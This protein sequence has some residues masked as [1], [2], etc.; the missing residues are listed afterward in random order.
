MT[1]QD[2]GNY[3]VLAGQRLKLK[4][5]PTDFSVLAEPQAVEAVGAPAVEATERLA[6]HMTR[7]RAESARQRDKA[8]A[9]VRKKEVAHHIYEVEGTGEEIVIG[10]QITLELHRDDPTTLRALMD[11]FNL[12]YVEP[13]PGAHVLRVT[14]ASG[15]NP[16]KVAN[17][18]AKREVVAACTPEVVVEIERHD[19][20]LFPEQ[21]YLTTDLQNHPDVL[22]GA[23]IDVVEAW[24]ITTGDPSVVVAAIDDGFDLD[25]PNL[26]QTR[27]HPAR[28]DFEGADQEPL[29]EGQDYHGT[30]VASIAVGGH[31]GGAMKGIAPGC[32][33]LPL[34]IGFGP[35][36]RPIDILDVFRFAAQHADVVNCSFGTPPRSFDV[37]TRPFRQAITQLTESGGRRGRGLV[38]VFSAA[39]DD[40]P[41]FL[42]GARNLNGVRY[43]SGSSIA[44]IPA[45][46]P[47]FSG[48]PMTPGVV[49]VGAMSSRKR[50]AGYSSWGPHLTVAAP[51]NNMHYI[52]SFTPPGTPGRQQFIANYRGL[53]QVAAVNRPGFGQPFSPI[54]RFDNPATPNIEEN[55]YTKSFGGTSGA[56]PVVTGVVALVLSANPN[57]SA[58][59]VRQILM[60]TADQNL[61]LTL[62]LANDP[63][64]QGLSGA[65]VDGRSLFFGAG[66]VDAARAVRRAR[67]LNPDQPPP[68]T[69]TT[70]HG[71]Q[72]PDLAI[73]DSEPAGVVSAIDCNV[74]GRLA[75]IS[76][77]V[78]ISHTYR[79]DLRIQLTSPTG[80][81][82]ELKRVDNSD[83]ASGVNVT[84]TAAA[85]A[86]LARLVQTGIEAGGRWTLNVSDNLFRDIGR[87]RSWTLDLRVV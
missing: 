17:E 73:P 32:T 75:E 48:Y 81:V 4:K 47:V 79:G 26:R 56:A 16:I 74:G 69:P 38:M 78:D 70:F 60:S 67:A 23:G 77:A 8:M 55:L 53:G 39:N 21:W 87:L 24:T 42:D 57:L 49:V 46:S 66:K 6:R 50:K 59:E 5:H 35:N 82:A 72:R 22:P 65:F 31:S 19:V 62:D 58:T 41:T 40:A 7:V 44:T 30:P 2:L 51:S 11:E 63:N 52:P 84:F 13:L 12:E 43:T 85:N 64:L 36:A 25:H 15:Q 80:F 20:A 34:R 10:D 61:D 76:V 18:L 14:A 37:F 86:D 54:A 45:G 83:A 27:R 33:F 28:F 71:E 9:E 1:D 3:V 29:P 68:V